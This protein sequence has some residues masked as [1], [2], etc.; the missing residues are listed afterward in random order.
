MATYRIISGDSHFVE[1][2]NMWAERVD[3]KFHARAPHTVKGY[4]GRE[5]EFFVCENIVPVAVAGFFGSG[6]SAEEAEKFLAPHY[7]N[8]SHDPFSMKDMEKAVERILRAMRNNE[9]VAIFSDYDADGIPGAVVLHDFFKK[10]GYGNF[11]NY[12]PDRHN[13]GF[14]L[15][16]TAIQQLHHS[17]CRLL[18]TVDCG[19][20]DV[21]EVAHANELGMEV[22]ITD[23][24]LPLRSL[25]PLLKGVSPTFSEKWGTGVVSSL[26]REVSPTL[27][28][29]WG[30][31]GVDNPPAEE[32]SAPFIKGDIP[33]TSANP[34]VIS[35][36]SFS[37]D[38][39]SF[40][41][42][43]WSHL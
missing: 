19:I 20:T 35:S 33:S 5:G 18:I 21:E 23:H 7:E 40:S 26:I 3:K 4:E 34:K 39:S 30:T 32:G 28:A 2:P 24:H 17:H 41:K 22:I 11:E 6:K 10:I 8:H 14:G 31:E 36:A 13:E 42:Y 25:S 12:I 16:T 43:P 37:G 38:G 15:N 29:K 1:P 27:S 9:R